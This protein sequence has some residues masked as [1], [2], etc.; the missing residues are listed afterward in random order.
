MA[1]AIGQGGI[2][3][4]PPPPPRP[5][6]NLKRDQTSTKLSKLILGGVI[7]GCGLTVIDL[8]RRQWTRAA[9]TGSL[10]GIAYWMGTKLRLGKAVDRLEE[11]VVE[12][13]DENHNY[14]YLNQLHMRMLTALNK[15]HTTV[16]DAAETLVGVTEQ[17]EKFHDEL[18][19]Y[20]TK[21]DELYRKQRENADD[22]A[23]HFS[24]RFARINGRS[25]YRGL[26]IIYNNFKEYFPNETALIQQLLQLMDQVHELE[27]DRPEMGSPKRKFPRGGC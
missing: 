2:Q 24:T 1:S 5:K 25:L 7:V 16:F 17:Q 12:L 19:S 20:F 13:A 10:T 15:T 6:N 14:T 26:D 8:F 21:A 4:P 23:H 11:Q 3:I 27:K 9:Y 18:V 22:T